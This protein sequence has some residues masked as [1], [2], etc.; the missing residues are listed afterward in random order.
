M[1]DQ[2]IS[3]S[4]AMQSKAN[5]ERRKK[6]VEKNR[7]L[8]RRIVDTIIFLGRQGLSFRGHIET[9]V[10]DSLNAG[11]FLEALK[12]LSCYDM[13]IQ[14][15]LSEVKENQRAM[16]AAQKGQRGRGSNCPC[17]SECIMFP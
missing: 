9:L 10:H 11:N 16:A 8:L 17:S 3:A 6:E 5:A 1:K 4:I 12:L 14:A 2:T 13:T 7:S 15:H